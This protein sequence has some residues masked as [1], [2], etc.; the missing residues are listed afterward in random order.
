MKLALLLNLIFS[1]S[2]WAQFRFSSMS[3]YDYE[4]SASA[5]VSFDD[6]AF[7]TRDKS[8]IQLIQESPTR[9]CIAKNSPIFYPILAKT[10]IFEFQL[11]YLCFDLER[12]D[13][14]NE[15]VSIIKFDEPPYLSRLDGSPSAIKLVNRASLRFDICGEDLCNVNMIWKRRPQRT[16]IYSE[17][18]DLIVLAADRINFKLSI[19][20]PRIKFNPRTAK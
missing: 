6:N 9:L 19:S 16:S 3:I 11:P 12:G 2:A 7:A 8:T 13:D 1:Y 15:L 18:F 17:D 20:A 5:M 4:G 10:G 14:T